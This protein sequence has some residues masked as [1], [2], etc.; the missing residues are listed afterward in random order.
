MEQ[1][2]HILVGIIV[3]PL[4]NI[5]RSTRDLY[6]TSTVKKLFH[7]NEYTTPAPAYHH[8]RHQRLVSNANDV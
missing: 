4:D 6:N 8:Q 5:S 1:I 7:D 2:E 3:I